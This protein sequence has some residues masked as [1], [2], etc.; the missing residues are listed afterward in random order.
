MTKT[1]TAMQIRALC[2]LALRD[3]QP[4]TV[5]IGFKLEERGYVTHTMVATHNRVLHQGSAMVT[6]L[7]P[8]FRVTPLGLRAAKRFD[9]QERE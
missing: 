3:V 5:S 1:L 2:D 7:E 9:R 8:H 4:Y 6:R